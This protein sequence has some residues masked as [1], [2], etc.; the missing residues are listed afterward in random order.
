MAFDPFKC[1]TSEVLPTLTGIDSCQTSIDQTQKI[2]FQKLGGAGFSSTTILT[3]TAWSASLTATDPD[4]IV[5]SPYLQKFMIASGE[6]IETGDA[7]NLNGLPQH[8]GFGFTVVTAEVHNAPHT[9]ITELK[10]LTELSSRQ[11]GVTLL[12]GYFFGENS[13]ITGTADANGIAIYNFTI[14]DV[15]TEGKRKPNIH[16]VRFLLPDGWSENLQTFN[17]SFDPNTL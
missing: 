5:I 7:N 8:E 11:A 14:S 13:R 2:A 9:V 3:N 4:K 16:K 6:V 12:K 15:S 17:A 10:K 1:P